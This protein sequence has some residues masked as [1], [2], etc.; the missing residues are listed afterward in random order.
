[1][2]DMLNRVFPGKIVIY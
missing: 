1:M 2:R